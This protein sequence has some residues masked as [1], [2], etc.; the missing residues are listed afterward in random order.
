MSDTIRAFI[1]IKL[2]EKITVSI[3]KIQEGLRSYG[4]K[5]KWVRPENIHLT[6][7]F[8]GN[9]DRADTEKV[10]SAISESVK[11]YAPLSLI[12]KG[13]GV[14]PNIKRPRIVWTGVAEQRNRLAGL[15]RHLDD[16]LESIGFQREKRPFKGHLTIG[17]VKQRIDSNRLMEAMKE[18]AKFESEA[19][20]INEIVLFKSELNPTGAVYT[21][22]MSASFSSL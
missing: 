1:A 6:L 22:L 3:S 14:F 9:I 16:H 21:Q 19:F 11:T 5:V 20:I 8:L 7:K 18:C 2:P 13:I 12:A 17:R 10:G 4:F 15:Q